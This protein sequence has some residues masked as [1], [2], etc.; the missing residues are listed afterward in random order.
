MAVV[1]AVGMLGGCS[2]RVPPPETPITSAG[3]YR[4]GPEDVI[5]VAVWRD[6]DMSRVVPV[7]PDGRISL[8]LLGELDAVDKTAPELATEIQQKLT[9]FVEGTPKVSVIVREVNSPRFFVLGEVQK[10][11][12]FP[13]RGGVTV[14][15]ALAQ[16]GGLA[17]YAD[18]EGIVIVRQVKDREA[19]YSVRY[20]DL[21]NQDNRLPMYLDKGDTIYVP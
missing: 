9:P 13:M 3:A 18:A 6:N 4:I 5:E 12:V 17:T 7:R 20:S 1:V 15:Q 14:L 19:R 8:P 21:V 16:A 10:P 2:H 11:G